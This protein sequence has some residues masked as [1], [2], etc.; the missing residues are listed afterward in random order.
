MWRWSAYTCLWGTVFEQRHRATPFQRLLIGLLRSI[1][2]LSNLI[3]TI[4]LGATKI[5]RF[6]GL[7]PSVYTLALID[8]PCTPLHIALRS[9][10]GVPGSLHVVFHFAPR[11][12][13]T[14]GVCTLDAGFQANVAR[15]T[16]PFS[17]DFVR[18]H[19]SAVLMPLLVMC[20]RRV[21]WTLHEVVSASCI[22]KF[23]P[24]ASL[25]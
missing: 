11:L 23:V 25:A 1:L 9:K 24:K 16:R 12:H 18:C 13:R 19:S 7:G 17:N 22:I 8:L 15:N 6:A 4:G 3:K 5:V 10:T 21:A 2:S 20:T 14:D